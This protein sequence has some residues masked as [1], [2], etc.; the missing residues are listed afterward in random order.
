MEIYQMWIVA[1]ILTLILTIIFTVLFSKIKGNLFEDIRGGIPRGVGIAPFIVMV[2]FFPKPFNYLIAVIGI[3]GFIDDVIGRK[4]LGSYMEVGQFFRGIGIIIVMIL[5]YTIMGPVSI[6]VAL[7]VQILN[8]AD[9]QPGTACMTVIIMS[10]TSFTLL[11]LMHS[12]SYYIPVLLLAICLGYVSQDY[13]GYIMMGEIGNH[14]FGVALGIC[15]AI[16]SASF[17]KIVAPTAFYS[18]E[19]IVMLVLFLI[20]A[21]II[22][23]LREETLEYYLETYLHIENPTFGDYLMD[24]LTGGGLGDLCRRLLLEDK[25]YT[26]KNSFLISLGVRRLVYNPIRTKKKTKKETLN[27]KTSSD[28][29]G[30]I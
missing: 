10:V 19:F 17:T 20:T 5:G 3:A 4:R 2:L 18:V 24:V 13:S 15:L 1:F 23:K 12:P 26:I 7:M 29:E 28:E 27:K 22:A 14:S 9:M 16:V 25:Q 8:I 30:F 21:I 11:T 6:L